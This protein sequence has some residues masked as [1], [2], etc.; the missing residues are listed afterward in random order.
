[1]SSYRKVRKA[2]VK[3]FG[4]F[5]FVKLSKHGKTLWKESKMVSAQETTYWLHKNK[6][7][8]G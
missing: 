2:F 1:M 4:Y 3:R 8:L 5:M 6:S 7:P